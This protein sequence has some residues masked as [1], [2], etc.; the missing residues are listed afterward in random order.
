MVGSMAIVQLALAALAVTTYHVQII[1]RISSAYPVWYWWVAGELVYEPR[2]GFAKN[3]VVFMV[4]YAMIQGVLFATFL[5][6]A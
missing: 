6:P 3:V 1:N 2:T 4:M 5:P